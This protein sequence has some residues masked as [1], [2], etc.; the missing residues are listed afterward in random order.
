MSS[1]ETHA[2]SNKLAVIHVLAGLISD[3]LL[4][5]DNRYR[6]SVDDFPEQFHRIIFSAIEHLASDGLGRIE[7]IDIDEFEGV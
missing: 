7:F 3:P 1:T 2:S 6:F 4:F 5:A